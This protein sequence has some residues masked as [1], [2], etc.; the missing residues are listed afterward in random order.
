MCRALNVSRSGFYRFMARKPSMQ[1]HRRKVL[2]EQVKSLFGEF[3]KRYGAP[4]L[5]RALNQQQIPCCTNTVANIMQELQLRARNGKAFRYSRFSYANVRVSDNVLN[6]QFC[7]SR[8]NEKWTSDIT[9]I[10]IKG[11]WHY[12]AT[13]MDLYSRAIVGW[14]F[15][16]HM[17]DALVERALLMAVSRR[18]V[19][20]G[21][22]V[23]SDRGVQYRSVSYQDLLMKIGAIPSMSRRSNCWDN[24]AMESFFSRLKVELIYGEKFNSIQEIKSS[25]FEYIEIFYNRVRQHSA[26]GY[27][28]PMEYERRYA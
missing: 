20:P 6:R 13:V 14:A 10:R 7:A 23:H 1:Q 17:T 8:P 5:T 15:D 4:R 24:A 27:L 19:K 21:L 18:K 2:R 28:S 22:I 26:L 25:I 9:Y 16:N 3:H 11:Q 12:L